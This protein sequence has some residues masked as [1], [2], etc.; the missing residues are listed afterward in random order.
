MIVRGALL[1]A[2]TLLAVGC[3]LDDPGP[4]GDDEAHW[5]G[6][7]VQLDGRTD[8]D[9]YNFVITTDDLSFQL[10]NLGGGDS[11][12]EREVPLPDGGSLRGADQGSQILLIQR[13]A[14]N[15]VVGPAEVEIA[16]FYAATEVG[17]ATFTP[18][19]DTDQDTGGDHC[20]IYVSATA[21]MTLDAPPAVT[22]RRREPRRRTAPRSADRT[23]PRRHRARTA[24]ASSDART[25]CPARSAAR[26]R[27][28][29]PR[30]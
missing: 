9:E 11:V 5:D 10:G 17:R 3:S 18:T 22:Q 29:R 4:C 14:D 1:A 16:A 2:L 19:Y 13:D 15:A 26:A 7:I 27:A 20:P 30:A 28:R 25:T 24:G 8:S 21:S 6:L 23:A 12:T